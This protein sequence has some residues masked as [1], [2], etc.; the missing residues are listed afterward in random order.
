MQFVTEQLERAMLKKRS[1]PLTSHRRFVFLTVKVLAEFRR[2]LPVV[3]TWVGLRGGWF[4][5]HATGQGIGHVARQ[6]LACMCFACMNSDFDECENKDLLTVNRTWY[7]KPQTAHLATRERNKDDEIR[8]SATVLFFFVIIH[9][10]YNYMYC[11]LP[12]VFS[13]QANLRWVRC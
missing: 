11:Y 13:L 7:N 6:W 2:S 8:E 12:L 4:S 9:L 3:G 1:V 5:F 10:H